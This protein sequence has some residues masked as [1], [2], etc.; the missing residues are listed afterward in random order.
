M[1]A[2]EIGVQENPYDLALQ[3][4][5]IAADALD[6]P[7]DIRQMIKYPEREL[8]VTL[9][10][11]MDNGHIRRFQG[12][13]V[14]HNTVR[15]PA[16]GG[17]RYHPNVTLDEVRALA[18]WMT[19]KCAVVNIPFGGGKGGVACHPKEL[20]MG[21][22]ERITR[23]YA[24]AILPLIGPGQDIP[25]PDVY[26]NPQ[27]MAWIMDTYSMTKGYPMPGVVTGKP[28]CLGGSLGRNEATGRGVFYTTVSL[29]EHLGLPIK[30][31]RVV[32]QG[33]GNAGSVA[34]QLLDSHQ[35]RVIAVSDSRGCVYNKNGLDIPRLMIYKES[36]GVVA[37]FPGAEP[38]TPA[39]LLALDCDILI[40]A[41]LENVVDRGNAA[42]VK[43]KIVAEAANGPLTPEADTIVEGRGGFIIP[44]ILCNAGGVTVSY[45]EWVQ[46]EQHLFWDAQDV[47][48]RLERVMK[49]AFNEVYKVHRERHVGMRVAANMV[50]IS[51]VAEATK[52][53]GLYP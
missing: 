27:I 6:L 13:R 48:N 12:Y 42:G 36:N 26:T 8:L 31:A 11:R 35:A 4:F 9:P 28:V 20:S 10:V 49:T 37:G 41:A 30:G 7:E 34:A 52:L 23:R 47:Y 17:I 1:N 18:T 40:P 24:S 19:W 38:I 53:R 2:T 43:A 39:E 22:T 45:F 25:A 21:E 3:N 46:D 32:V 14:Q 29:A 44:D 15:G 33:F 16:K 50:G 51:R 5:D